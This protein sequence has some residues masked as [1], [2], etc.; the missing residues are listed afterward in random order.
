M[1]PHRHSHSAGAGASADTDHELEQL[2]E[3]IDQAAKQSQSR[4]PMG[5]PPDGDALDDV[6][7]GGTDHE[8]RVDDPEES[9]IIGPE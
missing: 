9:P 5:D 6:A 7:G 2:D 4:R 8:Q 1:T 3:H